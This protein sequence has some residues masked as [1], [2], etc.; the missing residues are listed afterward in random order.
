[1][2]PRRVLSEP[3][4]L[5]VRTR[6]AIWLATLVALL[7]VATGVA[8]INATAVQG[9]LQV[10]V[11]IPPEVQR[12]AGF[13]GALTG[14]LM[15]LSAA[16]MRR[17]LRVAWVSTVVLLPVTALQG[18]AQSSD[19][20][21]PLVVLSVLSVPTV[22]VNYRRFDRNLDLSTTQLAAAAALAG[23]QFY[24][25]AGA[26][27]LQD[28]FNGVS[29]LTDAFYFTIVTASTV[30]YGDV[31]PLS[32][33][34]RLFGM[35]VVVLGVASFTVA[36]GSLLAPAIEARLSQALGTMTDAE[37]EL[38]EGHVVVLGYGDLTEPLVEE[39][40]DAADFVVITPDSDVAAQLRAHD[41]LV[42]VGDPSD[43]EPQA[44]AGIEHARAAV[45]ATND[46][47]QDALSIL[48]ARQLHP[49]V[50]I[51]AAAT[52]RENTEK[53]RRAGA[54]AVIS[55][56]VIGGHLLVE[57]ALGTGDMEDFADRL[58]DTRPDDGGDSGDLADAEELSGDATDE[59]DGGGRDEGGPG[60]DPK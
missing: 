57:S 26:Y 35:S 33:R 44:Q 60:R 34:A 58:L 10:F 20:S 52:D 8:N 2:N 7:S 39:L 49:D 54:D 6:A 48:T 24:G 25:T 9:P 40:A 50:R 45:A 41:I 43:E 17:R 1:M 3:G 22:L 18:L 30:G 55:P 47:A 23:T 59:S 28:D 5:L 14:F 53:L 12:A 13:T 21:L 16:G 15:L 46:D 32:A 29:S 51:V 42:V 19:F 27:A 11:D 31:T 56:A 36:L 38:L 4:A 37:I